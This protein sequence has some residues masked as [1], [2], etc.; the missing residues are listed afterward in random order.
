MSEQPPDPSS[1]SHPAPSVNPEIPSLPAVDA[2][3]QRRQI[4]DNNHREAS[5]ASSPQRHD[6]RQDGHEEG[7]EEE[8]DDDEEEPLVDYHRVVSPFMRRLLERDSATCLAYTDEVLAVG[9]ESGAVYILDQAAE[10][11]QRFHSHNAR[12]NDLSI[13][14]QGAY[15]ASCGA[16]GK[17]VVHALKGRQRP[18]P[19]DP[20]WSFDYEWA[21]LSVAIHPQYAEGTQNKMVCLG[22]DEYKLILNKRGMLVSSNTV[23]HSGEGTIFS[24]RWRGSLIAWAN[25]KGVKVFDV[26]THQKVTFIP[27]SNYRYGIDGNAIQTPQLALDSSNRPSLC[28]SSDDTLIFGW[29]FVV[30]IAKFREKAEMGSP[31]IKYAEVVEHF[32]LPYIVCGVAPFAINGGASNGESLLAILTCTEGGVN[33]PDEPPQHHLC[34]P[35]GEILFSDYVPVNQ[36][37]GRQ[38]LDFKLEHR[39][40]SMPN[41][42]VAPKDLLMVRRRSL[43]DHSV[44]LVDHE[45]YEEA[46]DVARNG[47]PDLLRA[48]GQ[49]CLKPLLQQRDFQRAANI[50]SQLNITD[51]DEWRAV[52]EAFDSHGALTHLAPFIPLPDSNTHEEACVPLGVDASGWQSKVDE[53]EKTKNPPLPLEA[54]LYE[55]LLLKL[56]ESDPSLLLELVQKWPIHR[57]DLKRLIDKL[58]AMTDLPSVPHKTLPPALAVSGLLRADQRSSGASGGSGVMSSRDGTPQSSTRGG[59]GGGGAPS[60]RMLPLLQVLAHLYE[61]T[62]QYSRALEVLLRIRSPCVFDL[63]TAHLHQDADFRETVAR[64]S[65]GLMTLDWSRA[66]SLF[67]GEAQLFSL[68]EVVPHLMSDRLLLHTYLKEL[69]FRDPIQTR[70]YHPLQVELFLQYDP[71]LALDFLRLADGHYDVQE[72]LQQCRNA[73]SMMGQHQGKGSGRSPA[74]LEAEVFLLGRAGLTRD[75]LNILLEQLQDIRAAVRFAAEYRDPE[76]WEQL[77]T[78]ALQHPAALAELLT[79]LDT[80]SDRSS[81]S[82]RDREAVLFPVGARG[83]GMGNGGVL[84]VT[85]LQILRRLPEGDLSKIPR[86]EAKLEKIF[87]D[88]Q[89]QR[90]LQEASLSLLKLDSAHFS[91]ALLTRRRRGIALTIHPTPL[92]AA[93]G[94]PGNLGPPRPAQP[95][96]APPPAKPQRSPPATPGLPPPSPSAPSR[97]SRET[98]SQRDR[99]GSSDERSTQISQ[100]AASEMMATMQPRPTGHQQLPVLICRSSTRCC[101]CDAYV[102]DAPRRLRPVTIS[103]P[104]P[105]SPATPPVF[106]RRPEADKDA[107]KEDRGRE[108]EG[109]GEPS[110]AVMR[111]AR[112]ELGKV[113]RFHF[114]FRRH[115][116][117]HVVFLCGHAVHLACQFD[118]T[119]PFSPRSHSG[120]HRHSRS[121]MTSSSAARSR[122]ASRYPPNAPSTPT[123]PSA[124]ARGGRPSPPHPSTP[125]LATREGAPDRP[126]DRGGTAEGDTQA[127]ASASAASAASSGGGGD[128]DEKMLLHEVRMVHAAVSKGCRLCA[129]APLTSWMLSAKQ[130]GGH[131]RGRSLSPQRRP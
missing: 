15:C 12:V 109:E 100:R 40:P 92:L 90:S 123:L 125:P 11:T 53:R 44:W 114:D 87:K 32:A 56:G 95:K 127:T 47:S 45:R 75:A 97:R 5:P 62:K 33:D 70:H 13:D 91:R 104:S 66:C 60:P 42:I 52:V 58:R 9:T 73:R 94:G 29:A 14:L 99:S 23:V 1:S 38:P 85:P 108:G 116:P 7:D 106:D 20:P 122:S 36:C 78:F 130:T 2:P 39:D 55:T 113:A 24:V 27:R 65:L 110:A 77:V 46:I 96:R 120:P 124:A 82:P 22:G 16:D 103:W 126:K 51:G 98:S 80:D 84:P 93:M 121:R 128:S 89:V 61:E 119:L 6:K 117:T 107:A 102:I 105:P 57:L 18:Q 21:V 88:L 112:E 35:S 54:S 111:R 37:V 63:I 43:E 50:I 3:P 86:I 8:D 67:V 10:E 30:K 69:F 59:G 129:R 25:L 31:P 131:I 101:L 81:A 118:A 48:I 79:H 49:S 41:Y 76:L 19:V 26:I 74:L 71:H 68:N 34:R 115:S 4:V 83:E 28:W 64:Q 72:A 17:V